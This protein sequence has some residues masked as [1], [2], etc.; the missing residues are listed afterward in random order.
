MRIQ[1]RARPGNGTTGERSTR[2]R[3]AIRAAFA[4]SEGP[5]SAEDVVRAARRDGVEVSLATVYRS[6]RTLIG[7]GWL[8]AV[9]LPG[10]SARYE[11][12]GKAHHHH[13]QC[14]ACERVFELEGCANVAQIRVPRGFRA[15]AHD[16][17]IYGSC[18]S[19][20]RPR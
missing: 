11:I 5:L 18:R 16:L 20:A 3:R 19:C 15:T 13:F 7:E 2:Q 8:T 4:N 12:A 6:L 9:E 17:A 1:L 10:T 14:L